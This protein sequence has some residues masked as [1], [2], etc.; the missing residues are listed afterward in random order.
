MANEQQGQAAP[1]SKTLIE[2]NFQSV[3]I[4][5][6][7]TSLRDGE[8][9]QLENLMPYA[10]GNL[11][12]V[13]GQLFQSNVP[14]LNAQWWATVTGSNTLYYSNDLVT[15]NTTT[16]TPNVSSSSTMAPLGTGPGKAVI[17]SNG[18]NNDE[19]ITSFG[20]P[21]VTTLGAA[22][23]KPNV[24]QYYFDIGAIVA[25]QYTTAT[26]TA[27]SVWISTNGGATFQ[28]Y[29]LPGP[30]TPGIT[31]LASGRWLI[32]DGPYQGST[33]NYFRYT[34]SPL[35]T[36]NWVIGGELTTA[37]PFWQASSIVS[38]GI[39][40]IVIDN[41]NHA[42]TTTN[43]IT[44]VQVATP[45]TGNAG[46]E[47]GCAANNNTFIFTPG[48]NL[49]YNILRSAD[50]G[51]TWN[52]HIAPYTS[53][54]TIMIYGNGAFVLSST[55]SKPVMS[56]DDGVTWTSISALPVGAQVGVVEFIS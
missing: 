31:R 49:G 1:S 54:Q 5:T 15:W 44:V 46:V 2:R 16:R 12:V 55:A 23:F 52:Q 11:A 13:P 24:A 35:P 37:P 10:P 8:C 40:A 32:V 48:N 41:G 3:N 29:A 17:F 7:P 34:D 25:L 45:T 30:G 9:A 36:G 47:N 43:G 28:S 4:S 51:A 33:G 39:T 21:I 20:F 6:S 18:T 56:T 38:D 26:S 53:G 19:V 42:Y 27:T 22:A 50:S 14:V